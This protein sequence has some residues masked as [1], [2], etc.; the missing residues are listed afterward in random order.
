[1]CDQIFND[2]SA[3]FVCINIFLLFMSATNS[4]KDDSVKL[5][6]NPPLSTKVL[7]K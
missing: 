3:T 6:D 4:M 7:L 2:L 5:I 1:M